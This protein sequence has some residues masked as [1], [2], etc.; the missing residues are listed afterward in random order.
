MA[1]FGFS[2][3]M[4]NP[5]WDAMTFM[6]LC[7]SLDIPTLPPPIYS[8]IS[9]TFFPNGCDRPI[10]VSENSKYKYAQELRELLPTEC[11]KGNLTFDDVESAF[12]RLALAYARRTT[13]LQLYGNRMFRYVLGERVFRTKGLPEHLFESAHSDLAAIESWKDGDVFDLVD[14][15]D[16][17]E[18]PGEGLLLR[19]A[20]TSPEVLAQPLSPEVLIW[21]EST[22]QTCHFLLMQLFDLPNVLDVGATVCLQGLKGAA[23]LN[24]A[25]GTLGERHPNGRYYVDLNFPISAVKMAIAN[26]KSGR[27]R[28][29]R[30]LISRDNLTRWPGA[31]DRFSL[32]RIQ[33]KAAWHPETQVVTPHDLHE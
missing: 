30:V 31:S 3:D 19:T 7:R 13:R 21:E 27:S 11:Q 16:C 20:T 12:L 25:E 4:V 23:W 29:E 6:T 33:E 10:D 5:D 14:E 8:L 15:Q 1:A 24:G 2:A 18:S 17:T 32:R 9:D 26:D 28:P 22:T